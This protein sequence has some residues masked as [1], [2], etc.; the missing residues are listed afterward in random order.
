[1]FYLFL[2]VEKSISHLVGSL[3]KAV[4]RCVSMVNACDLGNNRTVHYA[5]TVHYAAIAFRKILINVDLKSKIN[6]KMSNLLLRQEN[7]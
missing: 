5:I 4:Y 1:L 6:I 3:Y 2:S 7:R